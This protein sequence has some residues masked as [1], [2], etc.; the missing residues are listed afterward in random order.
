MIRPIKD[1]QATGQVLQFRTQAPSAAPTAETAT[2]T[3]TWEALERQLADLAMSQ[4]QKALVHSL[5]SATRKQAAF[6]PA[7]LVLREIFCIASVL[8]DETFHPETEEGEMS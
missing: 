3:F 6:K 2:P 4:A 7:E 8:M 5:V 1:I